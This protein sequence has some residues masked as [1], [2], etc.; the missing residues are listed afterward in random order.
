VNEGEIANPRWSE[1]ATFLFQT[2]LAQIE[3]PATKSSSGDNLQLLSKLVSSSGSK[4]GE[5]ML[6]KIDDLH[7]L[8]SSALHSLAY[9]WAGTR[10]WASAAAREAMVDKRLHNTDEV[11][12]FELE[13]IKE[14]M[15]GEW[16]VSSRDEIRAAT[17]TRQAE[18]AAMRKEVAPDLLVGDNEA[19]VSRREMPG[20]RVG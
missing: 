20:Q 17:A 7:K 4:Q 12:L 11:F 2:L 15:T 16:N 14:M 13:E 18:D 5:Q 1:D 8:Q 10:S 3:A 19:F 6:K 9:I